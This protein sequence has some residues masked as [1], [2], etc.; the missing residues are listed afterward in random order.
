LARVI[1]LLLI[2][3]AIYLLF[4]GFFR[5]QTRDDPP[6]SDGAKSL[7]GE[8]MVQCTRCGVNLPRSE[9]REEA[10]ALVCAANPGCRHKA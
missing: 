5:S 1:L 9:S 6:Q 2:A 4:R 10:G 8:D 7:E 3:F